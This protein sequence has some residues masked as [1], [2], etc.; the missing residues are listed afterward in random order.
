[1][2]RYFLDI[3]G[4]CA[5]V[6]DRQ[7]PGYDED[8]PGLHRVMLDVVEYKHGIYTDENEEVIGSW[9]VRQEDIDYLQSV[10]DK[11]NVWPDRER[12]LKELGI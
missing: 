3:R 7:H 9:K 1:M 12:K 8:Y 4:G 2:D 11:L 5:A 6:R 10:C